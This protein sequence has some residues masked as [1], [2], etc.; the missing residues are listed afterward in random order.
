MADWFTGQTASANVAFTDAQGR[1]ALVDGVP[2]WASSD[3]TVL[4]VTPAADGM[5]ATV[6]TVAPGTARVTVHADADLG[7]GVVDIVGVSED[8]NV[9]VNPNTFASVVTLTLG[10]PTDN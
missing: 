4:L 1:P 2:A 3:E 9:T 8:V 10:T 6:A 7:A 5:S